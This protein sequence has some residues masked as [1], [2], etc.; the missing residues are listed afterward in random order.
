VNHLSG[1]PLLCRFLALPTNKARQEKLF[2]NIINYRYTIFITLT[3][4]AR[5]AK[6]A[7]YV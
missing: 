1:T 4:T 6:K 5:Q 2:E 3:R 7:M